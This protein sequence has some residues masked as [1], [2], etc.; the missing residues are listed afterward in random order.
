[1]TGRKIIQIQKD[2]P[3]WKP[4][5]QLLAYN[6][7]TSDVD[8]PNNTDESGDVLLACMLRA[9]SPRKERI[10]LENKKKRWFTVHY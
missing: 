2:S 5:Q 4:I 10:P 1:M 3:K 8:N 7:S 6:L 9:V